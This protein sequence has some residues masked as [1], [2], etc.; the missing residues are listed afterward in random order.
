MNANGFGKR[1]CTRSNGGG[2]QGHRAN[3]L[4]VATRSVTDF[5]HCGVG[6]IDPFE[7]EA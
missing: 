2:R 7:D 1:R 4:M 3:Q 5:A 6:L